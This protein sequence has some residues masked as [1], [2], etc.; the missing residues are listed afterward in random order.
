VSAALTAAD[1]SA[2]ERCV[3]GGGVAV[4]P[5]DTVYG[6][7]CDPRDADAAARLYALKGRAPEKPAAVMF[8]R[9]SVL[10]SEV[11]DIQPAELLALDAL[12]PGPV[13]ILLANRAGLFAP[14][15][16]PEPGTIGLRVPLLRA[17]LAAL[18]A[19]EVPVMQSSANLS[20]GPDPRSLDEVPPEILGAADLVL[21]GGELPGTPSTVIDL[22]ALQSE[23]RWDVL[24]QGALSRAALETVLGQ[25]LHAR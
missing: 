18:A 3:A 10:L 13:T 5:S 17:P 16:G 8:F 4:F 19:L 23:G 1:A 12:L 7:C 21:D 9:T 11:T 15:C 22:R 24:R 14:A 25:A 2:L 20:G 6:L